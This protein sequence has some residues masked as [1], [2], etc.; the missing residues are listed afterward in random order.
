MSVAYDLCRQCGG[1]LR[2]EGPV[3]VR[4]HQCGFVDRRE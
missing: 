1:V 3:M 4:C 2:P